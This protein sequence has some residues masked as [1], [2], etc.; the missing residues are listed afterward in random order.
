V[1]EAAD[2]GYDSLDAHAEAAVLDGAILAQVEIPLEGSY[3][4][5]ML[6]NP[7]KQ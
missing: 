4:E 3:R 1:V 5:P 2:P 6:L 7:L